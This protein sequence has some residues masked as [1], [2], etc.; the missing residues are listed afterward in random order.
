MG[1]TTFVQEFTTT[2]APA[3]LFKALIL[4][5]NN[6]I[7]KLLPQFI[8]NVQVLQGDGG[9]GTIEQIN[10]TDA[11]PFKFVKHRTDEV[12]KENLIFMYSLIE[13]DPLGD[14]LEYISY[15]IKFEETSDGGCICKMTS[16]YHSI[17]NSEITEEE[18]KSGKE[19]AFA[20]YKVV[21]TYLLENPHSY[22]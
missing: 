10:F 8:K 1:V 19:S 13:G 17:G 6:L 20:I 15:D 4:D 21:E 14:K 18:I 22:A 2:I 3:R 11:S 9:P 7:P 16:K 5:S 12:D